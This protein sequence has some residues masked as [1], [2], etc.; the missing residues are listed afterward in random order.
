MPYLLVCNCGGLC[1]L[2]EL[3]LAIILV[4]GS[5]SSLGPAL[6]SSR[7][8]CWGSITLPMPEVPKIFVEATRFTA[9]RSNGNCW[10]L[11]VEPKTGTFFCI[12]WTCTKKSALKDTATKKVHLR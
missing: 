11:V 9:S 6:P 5:V 2:L 4:S 1:V 12:S 8:S 3:M 10:V 7:P